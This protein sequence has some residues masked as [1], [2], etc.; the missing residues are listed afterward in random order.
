MKRKKK[1]IVISGTIGVGK[2]TVA[3]ALKNRL[4]DSIMLDGDWCWM[5]HPW[6][7][8]DENK[9]MVEDNIVFLINSFLRN[10]SFKYVIFN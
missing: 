10:P 4:D 1:L 7:F 2:T 6:Q 8:I 5:M 9:K 3:T